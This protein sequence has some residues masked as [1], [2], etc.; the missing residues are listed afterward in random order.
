VSEF[1]GSERF[2]TADKS[3]IKFTRNSK[4]DTQVELRVVA[5]E[6]AG[7]M[8]RIRTLAYQTYRAAVE[9]VGGRLPE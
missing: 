3:S 8:D 1:D 6:D 9:S 7:E 4:G 5:G 2:A